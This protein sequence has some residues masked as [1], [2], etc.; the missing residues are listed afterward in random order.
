MRSRQALILMQLTNSLRCVIPCTLGWNLLH[1][2]CS[3]FVF[4]QERPYLGGRLFLQYYIC[5]A[6]CIAFINASHAFP[7]RDLRIVFSICFPLESHSPPR[8]LV[9]SL[10]RGVCSL[11]PIYNSMPCPQLSMQSSLYRSACPWADH[12]QARLCSPFRSKTVVQLR[13]RDPQFGCSHVYYLFPTSSHLSNSSAN[14]GHFH[15]NWMGLSR[16]FFSRRC[17]D[18]AV[19]L[20]H[21]IEALETSGYSVTVRCCRGMVPSRSLDTRSFCDLFVSTLWRA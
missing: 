17:I 19:A 5:D 11:S 18:P 3:T 10:P 12:V 20:C 2:S 7:K 6:K 15:V 4:S 16:S 1:V 13:A 21:W 8:D 9:S 14:H